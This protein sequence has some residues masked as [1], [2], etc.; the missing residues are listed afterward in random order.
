VTVWASLMM[1]AALNFADGGEAHRQSALLPPEIQGLQLVKTISGDAAAGTIGRLH[2]K[3]VAPTESQIGLYQSGETKAVLYVSRFGSAAEAAA[4]L[5]MMAMRIA[6]GA[7]GFGHY[8][9]FSVG[10]NEVHFVLGQGQ[11]HY[12]FMKRFDVSWLAAPPDIARAGLAQLLAV[13]VDAV[14]ALFGSA[15]SG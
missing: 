14:P 15:G 12:F 6:D 5:Q 7:E 2:D 8:R 11:A 3:S 1:V 10:A 13:D 4:V 9:R